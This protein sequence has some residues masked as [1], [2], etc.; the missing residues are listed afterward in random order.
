MNYFAHATLVLAHDRPLTTAGAIL[1]DLIRYAG[2]RRAHKPLDWADVA[3]PTVDGSSETRSPRVREQFEQVADGVRNHLAADAVFHTSKP[4]LSAL[5]ALN[6]FIHDKTPVLAD[7]WTRWLLPHVVVELVL[8]RL[9]VRVDPAGAE[10]CYHAIDTLRRSEVFDRI[11]D[12]YHVD[13]AVTDALLTQWVTNRRLHSYD[14]NEGISRAIERTLGGHGRRVIADGEAK[15]FA[16]LLDHT[17]SL[18]GEPYRLLP[19]MGETGR[20]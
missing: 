11:C 9:L 3:D 17:E 13:P 2:P 15:A 19:P 8:D 5:H 12:R 14:T 4:F 10:L 7:H 18:I 20:R 6:R 16:L 1:P